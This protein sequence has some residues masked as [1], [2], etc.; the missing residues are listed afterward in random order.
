MRISLM[1]GKYLSK[2]EFPDPAKGRD[3][4]EVHALYKLLAQWNHLF[5]PI[6]ENFVEGLE[7]ALQTFLANTTASRAARQTVALGVAALKKLQQEKEKT[8]P[9]RT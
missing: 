4:A 8:K 5:I 2:Y 3:F 9:P 6:P 7:A 1:L